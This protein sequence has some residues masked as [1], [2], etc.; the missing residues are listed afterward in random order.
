MSTPLVEVLTFEGCPHA[1]PA[2]ELVR[3][4]LAETGVAATVLRVD[5]PDPETAAAQ[6]FLGS[7]TIRVNGRDI[8]PHA[9]ERAD[10]VLSCRVYRTEKGF[11]GQPD[12]R[13]L[14]NALR[15]MT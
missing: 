12:E 15:A 6:R 2:L 8:E 3:R 11:K 1:E 14:R 7:P 4:V 13:W 10:Y 9:D 5:V